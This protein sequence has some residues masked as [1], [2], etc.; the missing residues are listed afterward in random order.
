MNNDERKNIRKQREKE[1]RQFAALYDSIWEM[2]R[3]PNIPARS[4]HHI[5]TGKDLPS[6]DPSVIVPVK[7][8]LLWRSYLD[9]IEDDSPGPIPCSQLICEHGNSLFDPKTADDYHTN[10]LPVATG[11]AMALAKIHGIDDRQVVVQALKRGER[12]FSYHFFF[13]F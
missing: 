4:Q 13:D 5:L 2:K 6:L 8:L 7:W 3:N 1:K 10:F 12:L 9:D 11:D